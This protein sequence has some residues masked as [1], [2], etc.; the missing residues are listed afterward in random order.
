MVQ[1]QT[2]GAPSV[3]ASVSRLWSPKQLEVLIPLD[4]SLTSQ[5]EESLLKRRGLQGLQAA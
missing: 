5:P 4:L 2:D 1:L 3:K